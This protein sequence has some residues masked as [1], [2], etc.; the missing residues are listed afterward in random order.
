M[1]VEGIILAAGLSSRANTFKMTLPFNGKTVIENTIDN[2]L[3]TCNRVIVVGGYRVELLQPIVKR[4]LRVELVYNPDYMQ[5]MYS[6]I[7][8][9]MSCITTERFFYTPGDY[10]LITS[11]VYKEML[12]IDAPIVIPTFE[13]K[14]GHPVL[15]EGSIIKQV[16]QDQSFSTLRDVIKQNQVALMEINCRGILLDLDTI[17]DY[18]LLQKQIG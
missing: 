11:Q 7:K 10:P 4:Y 15:F 5:G 9:G 16:L 18:K 1:E 12:T 2:M 8:R 17:E 3:V 14:K 13:D 6:S